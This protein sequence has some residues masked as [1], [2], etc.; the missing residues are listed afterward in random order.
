MVKLSNSHTVMTRFDHKT[1]KIKSFPLVGMSI[2]DIFMHY[3]IVGI[4]DETSEFLLFIHEELFPDLKDN[5]SD[6]RGRCRKYIDNMMMC[7]I[8][9]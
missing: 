2:E 7:A 5:V 4:N 6:T 8:Q 1:L 9:S 3:D